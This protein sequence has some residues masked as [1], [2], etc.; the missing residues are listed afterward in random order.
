M[1]YSSF[2]D[3]VSAFVMQKN[4][5][6]NDSTPL[7][8]TFND[9]KNTDVNQNENSSIIN[10]HKSDRHIGSLSSA[11]D[12]LSNQSFK[13]NRIQMHNLN[14]STCILYPDVDQR[15]NIFQKLEEQVTYLTD[16]HL[17]KVKIHGKRHSIPRKQAAYGDKYVNGKELTYTYSG[18]KLTPSPWRNAPILY[19]IRNHLEKLTGIYFNFVL[20]NCYRNG[21]DRMGHHKD[22]EKEIDKEVP[23]A[24]ISFG[25]E[26]VLNF[27]KDSK[28][29]RK[30]STQNVSEYN[31]ELKDGMLLLM[32]SPTNEFWYH[33]LPR[34]SIQ[35]CPNMRINLTY[36]KIVIK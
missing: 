7:S 21:H 6:S 2:S 10:N 15:K 27:K 23:I 3:F 29:Q 13:W 34:Q 36:R 8:T 16:P 18:I 35:I 12:N 26:R 31:I 25:Q 1:S 33:G 11:V 5:F 32:H 14:L 20:V 17:T 28:L 24:S 19:E 4:Q 22:D 30:P 9:K